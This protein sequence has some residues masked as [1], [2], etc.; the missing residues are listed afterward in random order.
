MFIYECKTYLMELSVFFKSIP[1][2]KMIFQSID[3]FSYFSMKIY[4]VRAH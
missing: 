1:L 4:V 2:D 3:I